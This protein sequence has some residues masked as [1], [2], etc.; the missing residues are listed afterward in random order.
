MRWTFNS[1]LTD[2]R[3][4]FALIQFKLTVQNCPEKK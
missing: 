2:I 1:E 3:T 4:G